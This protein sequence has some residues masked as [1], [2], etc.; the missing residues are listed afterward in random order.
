MSRKNTLRY[1]KYNA[2]IEKKIERCEKQYETREKTQHKL[3]KKTPNDD[4]IS[5]NRFLFERK[6]YKKER[7]KLNEEK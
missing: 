2:I 4:I 7:K 1:S 5:L 6:G 3:K